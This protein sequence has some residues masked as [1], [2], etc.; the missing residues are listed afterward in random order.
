MVRGGR[1]RWDRRWWRGR[2]LASTTSS[3]LGSMR[4]GTVG[5][6]KKA[7]GGGPG[8]TL[9]T[10]AGARVGGSGIGTI[11]EMMGT[12]GY[13]VGVLEGVGTA[14]SKMVARC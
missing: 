10:G 3:G 4:C 11:W 13:E 9:G 2:I 6:G 7:P 12:L 8:V 14:R 5:A 1:G